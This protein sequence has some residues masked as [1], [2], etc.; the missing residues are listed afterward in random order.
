MEER[1]RCI[2]LKHETALFSAFVTFRYCLGEA[3]TFVVLMLP[4]KNPILTMDTEGIL[5]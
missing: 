2:D 1:Q 3:E 5:T 4:S